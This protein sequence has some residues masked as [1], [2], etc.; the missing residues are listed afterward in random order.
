MGFDFER[1]LLFFVALIIALTVHEAAHAF[2]SYKLGDNTAR[3]LGRLSLNPL[4]HLDPLGTV[5]IIFMSVIGFG[6]GW[7]KPVPVN[8]YKLRVGPRTGMAIVA[9]AGPASNI[10]LAAIFS[11]IWRQGIAGDL[12]PLLLTVVVVNVTLAVFN[13]I[14]IPP[15]DGFKVLMGLVPSRI[16]YTMAPLEQYG[17]VL[18]LLLVFMGGGILRSILTTFGAPIMRAML[19]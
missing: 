2:A 11:T 18:L 5:M 1:F 9:A 14:P 6:I 16:A 13:M 4:V 10:L 17:P 12:E 3:S 8:P 7:A 19:G 15:L